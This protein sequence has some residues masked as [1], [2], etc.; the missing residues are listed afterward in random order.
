MKRMP[1]VA[2]EGDTGQ[3]GSGG[4]ARR[5]PPAAVQRVAVER[6]G[7]P[8]ADLFAFSRARSLNLAK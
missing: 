5:S 8:A 4:K 3:R 2:A 7:L 6:R 1:K